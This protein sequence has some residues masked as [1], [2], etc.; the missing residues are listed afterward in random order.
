MKKTFADKLFFYLSV[1]KCVCCKEKLALGK[2]ALCDKCYDAYILSK[3][4]KCS[5]CFKVLP[6]CSCA[7]EY[8][9]SRFVHKLYKLFRYAR[10]AYDGELIASNELIYNVKRDKRRDLIDL[11]SDE[12]I[13]VLASAIKKR[14]YIITSV[15]RQRSRVIKYG[16]DH[17][18]SIARAISQKLGIP[19]VKYLK[20]G[21]KVAQKKTNGEERRENA[22]FYPIREVDLRGKSIILFDDI[23]TTGASMGACAMQLKALGAREIIGAAIA[24]AFSDKYVPFLKTDSYK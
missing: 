18:E 4:R 23:V 13:G 5:V 8:L 16:F 24:V 10:P 20:S 11:I 19:Y 21:A 12:M 22:R 7:N 2:R 14:E 17:S 9:D 1:P 6:E 3:K 15:P